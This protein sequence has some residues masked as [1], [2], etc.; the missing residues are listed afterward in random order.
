M[1]VAQNTNSPEEPQDRGL[2]LALPTS[3]ATY[4]NRWAI[5]VGV[6]KYKHE[7]LNLKYAD[8]DAEEL[9]ELLLTPSGGGFAKENVTKLVNEEATTANITRALRSFL[10]KPAKEDIVL[11]YFACHG[12]PDL[13]RPGVV[14]LLT[15][16]AD[17]LDIAGT[18]L[19]MREI[20]LSLKENLLAERVIILADT[21]HSAAIGGGIGRRCA[22]DNSGVVN[23][24]L[25]EV[26][27]TRPGLALLTSAEGNEVSFEDAKWGGGHGVFTHYLLEGM[28]GA[29]DRSPKNGVVTV[30]ELF[31]YVR[32][33]VKRAT[34]NRQHPCIG[35]NSYDRNLPVAIV[36]LALRLKTIMNWA[37]SSVKLD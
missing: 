27:E 7:T 25:Q 17:P 3:Y 2:Q 16:D 8:R 21:C 36:R 34:E 14:Y 13:D 35:T 12:S 6:S 22:D 33:N 18:A 4:V 32:D 26:S 20:D 24:Y 19:P 11:I 23:K 5:V 31:E 1:P 10:K 28:K 29:A 15:H 37:I 9:Y 30:S